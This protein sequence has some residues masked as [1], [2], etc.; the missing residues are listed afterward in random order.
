[1][2]LLE[3]EASGGAGAPSQ[4]CYSPGHDGR[5]FG[6]DAT[7]TTVRLVYEVKSEKSMRIAQEPTGEQVKG[8]PEFSIAQGDRLE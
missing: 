1:M 6:P 7:D 8:Y 2:F 5:R 3:H 4:L